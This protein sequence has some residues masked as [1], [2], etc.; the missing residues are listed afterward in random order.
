VI[1]HPT[2]FAASG[3]IATTAKRYAGFSV[4]ETAGST[5][6][7]RVWDSATGATG[8]V[9]EEIALVAYESAREYY[10]AGI[11]TSG[12]TGIYVEVVSG[13]VTGSIRRE[14]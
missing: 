5:A 12:Q 4:R 10:P 1:V 2:P 6:T 7:V 13:T 9:M 14:A 11:T 8:A 3:V